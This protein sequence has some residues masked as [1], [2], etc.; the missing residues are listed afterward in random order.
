MTAFHFVRPRN[1]VALALAVIALAGNPP[2]GGVAHAK[3]WAAH[4]SRF[5]PPASAGRLPASPMR[6]HA[7]LQHAML[8][9]PRRTPS[10]PVRAHN[11][12]FTHFTTLASPRA[13]LAGAMR[14]HPT[15]PAHFAA[16]TPREARLL[17]TSRGAGAP[18]P[19]RPHPTVR[20][21]VSATPVRW[22]VAAGAHPVSREAWIP[23][24][25]QRRGGR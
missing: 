22:P 4:P 21:L 1:L 24:A 2:G 3:V 12:M 17:R 7:A 11:A 9:T 18:A 10:G 13:S 14:A 5:A 19:F 25:V 6:T 20:P 23:P 8:I 16:T 15:T